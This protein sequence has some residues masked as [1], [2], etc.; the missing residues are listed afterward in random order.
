[1]THR[2]FTPRMIFSWVNDIQGLHMTEKNSNLPTIDWTLGSQLTDNSGEFLHELL[3]MFSK[4]MPEMQ[5][6]L[7][8]AF[9]HKKKEEII[10][11]LHKLQGS[12]VYCGLLKLKAAI[13]ELSRS[14][15]SG[16]FSKDLL[17]TVNQEMIA[18]VTELKNK[19][20]I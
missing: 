16:I 11:I 2:Y 13:T 5:S 8:E 18:V 9:S 7:N 4:Q 12:C 1:L 14:I 17:D 15:R 6:A 3:I 20:I 19:K 10:D